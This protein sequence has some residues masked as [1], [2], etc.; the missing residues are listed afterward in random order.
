MLMFYIS[1]TQL[2]IC[3]GI[4]HVG[5]EFKFA[6]VERGQHFKFSVMKC[7]AQL[8][9]ICIVATKPTCTSIPQ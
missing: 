7:P 6:E 3:I 5:S 8:Q 2:I 4:I 1:I 9:E